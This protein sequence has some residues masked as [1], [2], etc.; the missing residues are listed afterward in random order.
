MM[1]DSKKQ[2][3]TANAIL[4]VIGIIMISI[5]INIL[6]NRFTKSD[7]TPSAATQI[8]ASEIAYVNIDSLFNNYQMTIDLKEEFQAKAT[9]IQTDIAK[10]SRSLENSII[11]FDERIK[12]GTISTEDASR[13]RNSLIEQENTLNEYA[14]IKENELANDEQLM[15]NQIMTSIQEFIKEYNK[16]NR[17]KYILSTSNTTIVVLDAPQEL[18][19][20]KELTEALNK[21]YKK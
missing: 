12:K 11:D 1:K 13:L 4:A 21:K 14:M 17:Y 6:M 18:N 10:K 8:D 15:I 2:I 19:I 3:P 7:S 5:G 20:T 9:S 16:D